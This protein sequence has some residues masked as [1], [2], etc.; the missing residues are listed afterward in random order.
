MKNPLESVQCK[1]FVPL[2][3]RVDCCCIYGVMQ[4]KLWLNSTNNE[5][6]EVKHDICLLTSCI[7][8]LIAYSFM[9]STGQFLHW[10]QYWYERCKFFLNEGDHVW[11][12]L[13]R[14]EL[15]VWCHNLVRRKNSW[16]YSGYSNKK[17]ILISN[18]QSNIVLS[19]LLDREHR[20]GMMGF[21]AIE[22]MGTT[23]RDPCS[24]YSKTSHSYYL[25]S[26]THRRH[27]AT[28]SKHQKHAQFTRLKARVILPFNVV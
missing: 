4:M 22:H 1:Y 2:L 17:P 15:P 27:E 10:H 9:H 23:G 8:V 28:D 3:P 21:T 16:S 6:Y 18:Q 13:Y 11:N 20:S 19:L 14:C 7:Y 12:V 26:G 25:T 24:Q 5:W